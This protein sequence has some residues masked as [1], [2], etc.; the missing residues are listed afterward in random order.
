M[1]SSHLFFTACLCL[2]SVFVRA[3]ETFPFEFLNN[4]VFPDDQIYDKL[5]MKTPEFLSQIPSLKKVAQFDKISVYQT[6]F[7]KDQS[8]E[9]SPC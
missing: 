8:G 7:R 9:S 2:L 1:K 3:E 6:N 5:S 4:S